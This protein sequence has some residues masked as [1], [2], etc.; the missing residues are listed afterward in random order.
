MIIFKYLGRKRC[1]VL[2][3]IG[4]ILTRSV[5]G[6][7]P[8]FVLQKL[9]DDGLYL[10]ETNTVISCSLLLVL[11]AWAQGG[12]TVQLTKYGAC[13]G[14]TIA[15]EMRTDVLKNILVL[16]AESLLEEGSG[17]AMARLEEVGLVPSLLSP[18]NMMLA[19]Y[20]IQSILSILILD[21]IN[22][23]FVI[24]AII[25][26]IIILI[27]D[28]YFFRKY[29][30]LILSS[31]ESKAALSSLIYETLSGRQTIFQSKI[32]TQ[33]LE[34]VQGKGESLKE[35]LIRQAVMVAAS[36]EFYNIINVVNS[37]IV[38]ILSQYILDNI[39]VG[40]ILSAIQFTAKV[41]SPVL[42]MAATYTASIPAIQALK[43]TNEILSVGSAG[44]D[45]A[46]TRIKTVRA[47]NVC[48]MALSDLNERCLLKQTSFVIEEPGLYLI[49][50][51]NGSGKSCLMQIISGLLND[52][53][54]SL[55]I[56]GIEVRDI[57]SESLYENIVYLPQ[58]PFIFNKTIKNNIILDI[59]SK[60]IQKYK[61]IY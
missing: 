26:T 23:I 48:L 36:S 54:G 42:Q 47:R 1:L 10:K 40:E 31:M 52:Y 6:I 14:E 46:I 25:P 18:G 43:R 57:S 2:L 19:S 55:Q 44:K 4:L 58:K 56:N 15:L 3:L 34:S 13:L 49:K 59:K 51:K 8:V 12:L 33:E 11:L 27:T 32:V 39:S 21:S 35:K 16:D 29:N 7:I 37:S 30:K 60:N 38:Y 24:V 5:A 53:Q 28:I 17:Y 45:K 61:Y 50:G 41:Y 20:V 9:I 22:F